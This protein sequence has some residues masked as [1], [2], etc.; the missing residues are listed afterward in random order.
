VGWSEGGGKVW[1]SEGQV[2]CFVPHRKHDD[3]SVANETVI[4]LRESKKGE[5]VLEKK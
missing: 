4:L 2:G 1:Q 5:S 3:F